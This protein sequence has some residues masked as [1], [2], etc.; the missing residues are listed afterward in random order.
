MPSSAPL[1]VLF[2][3]TGNIARSPM[4]AGLLA[5]MARER[6]VPIEV[7][8]AGLVT[9]DRP[10]APEA[11]ALLARRGIDIGEHRSTLLRPES[12]ADADLILGMERQHAREAAVLAP[13]RVARCHPLLALARSASGAPREGA[14]DVRS[15]LDRIGAIRAPYEL[16]GRDHQD[17]IPDPYG[18]GKAAF[19]AALNEIEGALDSLAPYLLRSA[20][21]R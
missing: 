15:W 9:E 8:S 5:A 14:E 17:A 4:A 21:R 16:L 1:R 19:R 7:R 13:E 6:G 12:V 2:V 20:R 3:C 18:R 11:V 10:A